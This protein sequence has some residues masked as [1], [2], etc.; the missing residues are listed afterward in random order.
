MKK[1]LLLMFLFL[2]SPHT[3]NK[4]LLGAQTFRSAAEIVFTRQTK[5][6]TRSL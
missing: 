4:R 3:R 2:P 1:V 5:H 6:Q